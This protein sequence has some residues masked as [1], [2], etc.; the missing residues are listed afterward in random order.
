MDFLRGVVVNVGINIV[1]T[2]LPGFGKLGGWSVSKALL[3]KL[4]TSEVIL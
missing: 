3:Y 1:I 4:T 2:C